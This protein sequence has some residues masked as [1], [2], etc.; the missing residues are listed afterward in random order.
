M[1]NDTKIKQNFEFDYYGTKFSF[2]FKK[3]KWKDYNN[4]PASEI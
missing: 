1:I 4:Y 3:K 2:S